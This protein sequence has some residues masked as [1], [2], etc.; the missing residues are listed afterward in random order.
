MDMGVGSFVFSQGLVSAIPLLK[1]PKHLSS[2]LYPKVVA[3]VRKSLPVI[4][5][6]VVRVLLVKGTEYPVR[7]CV[8]TSFF[9]QPCVGARIRVRNTLEFLHNAGLA[10]DLSGVP[11]PHYRSRPCVV[12][13]R[14]RSA[15]FVL[16]RCR[17]CLFLTAVHTVQQVALSGFGLTQYVRTTPRTGPISA[18]KEGIA[19]LGGRSCIA[20]PYYPC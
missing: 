5:L 6:G 8:Y 18:N 9:N 14:R 11:P 7:G 3:V 1:D 12:F 20:P 17:C 2:P 4:A 19:S 15:A 10:P 13:G 16:S